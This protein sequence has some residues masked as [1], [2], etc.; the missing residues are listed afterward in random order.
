MNMLVSLSDL[1]D[2]GEAVPIP[3]ITI[4][5]HLV[6]EPLPTIDLRRLNVLPGEISENT[7]ETE[8]V[9]IITPNVKQ[10]LPEHTAVT[11]SIAALQFEN[12]APTSFP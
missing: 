6:T 9:L 5:I 12:A 3:H 10:Q 11:D 1:S 2:R 8:I 4:V 7:P